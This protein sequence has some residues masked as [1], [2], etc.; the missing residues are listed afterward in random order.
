MILTKYGKKEWGMAIAIFLIV[1]FLCAV[2][3]MA[4]A[5]AVHGCYNL[6]A[7]LFLNHL[8]MGK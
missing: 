2:C 1:L 6:T 5:I 4:A 8:F 7:M 3:V